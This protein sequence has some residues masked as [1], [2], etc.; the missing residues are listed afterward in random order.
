MWIARN[1][2][3]V[4][5]ISFLMGCTILGCGGGGGSGGGG[6]TT[7]TPPQDTTQQSCPTVT[8]VENLACNPMCPGDGACQDGNICA[9]KADGS[10]ACV[11][12]TDATQ[13]LGF[14]CNSET[15]CAQGGCVTVPNKGLKCQSFCTS[16]A[17]CPS[18]EA[19]TL[20]ATVDGV[21]LKLCEP[22]A[23]AGACDVFTQDCPTGLAC[24]LHGCLPPGTAAIGDECQVTD[25]SNDCKPGLVCV[26]DKCHEVCNPK[27]GGAE[28]KCTK[29]CPNT[30]A[31][32]VGNDDVGICS[33][34]DG[35]PDCNLL[36]QDC[37]AGEACY[38]T[39]Q[40][41]RC[42]DEGTTAAGDSCGE[43]EECVK[44]TVCYP[45]NTKCRP[46]CKPSDTT[47]P[48]C[49]DMFSPCSNLP[50]SGGAGYCDE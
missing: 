42:R 15:H 29:K 44:G 26:S 36:T 23:Q 22:E 18:G 40:G 6:D 2:T 35:E 7:A 10:V 3:H 37:P 38:E 31:S 5:V 28:P 33:Q 4:W 47:H 27:S 11:A 45:P 46:I 48:E 43:S 16:L 39:A 21:A 20:S 14:G 9:L 41:P 30:T 24:Y 50:A 17:D 25:E 49:E 8:G 12:T 19:C 13:D 34:D 32:I 1:R